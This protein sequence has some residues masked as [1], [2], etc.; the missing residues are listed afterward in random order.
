MISRAVAQNGLAIQYASYKAKD[1]E[2]LALLAIQNNGS[3]YRFISRRLQNSEALILEALQRAPQIITAIPSPFLDQDAFVKQ[4]LSIDL[5]LVP[6]L[7]P[8]L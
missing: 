4:I 5:S 8:R 6:F 1:T 7:S 2:S 3:A